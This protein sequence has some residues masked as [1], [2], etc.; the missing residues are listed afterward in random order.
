MSKYTGLLYETE[1]LDLA[2]FLRVHGFK[3]DGKKSAGP[4]RTKF[5][6]Q[7]PE[8]KADD[9]TLEFPDSEIATALQERKNLI[10]FSK[11]GRSQ[12]R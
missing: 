7:D 5:I 11:S 4:G 3:I 12:R 9:L 2:T 10:S 8:E 1:C 6:F